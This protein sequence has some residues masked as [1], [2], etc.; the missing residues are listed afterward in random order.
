MHV[1]P[2]C[3]NNVGIPISVQPC[4][5]NKLEKENIYLKTDS[6]FTEAVT[7]LLSNSPRVQVTAAAF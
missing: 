7:L 5:G 4:S 3:Y 1:C 2:S 6:G